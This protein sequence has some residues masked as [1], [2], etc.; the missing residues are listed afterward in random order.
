VYGCDGDRHKQD[1][2]KYIHTELPVVEVFLNEIKVVYIEDEKE[3]DKG[4]DKAGVI[5]SA[6]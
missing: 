6:V 1:V 2:P 4:R 3:C 5:D